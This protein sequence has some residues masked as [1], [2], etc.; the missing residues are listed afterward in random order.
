[1]SATVSLRRFPIK[2]KDVPSVVR[3][4][5]VVKVVFPVPPA[6]FLFVKPEA[7]RNPSAGGL[8]LLLLAFSLRSSALP[9]ISIEL[10]IS[11]MAEFGEV[12]QEAR[13]VFDLKG[14]K[15]LG[16]IDYP[17]RPIDVFLAKQRFQIVKPDPRKF[18]TPFL[19]I[20]P[21]SFDPDKKTGY[22]GL[23]EG[24]EVIFGRN[25]PY[26]FQYNPEV[27]REHLSI[28]VERGKI[29]FKDLNSTNGSRVEIPLKQAV[30]PKY[31]VPT[32]ETKS[33]VGLSG[34]VELAKQEIFEQAGKRSPGEIKRL[35]SQVEQILAQ[36]A[37]IGEGKL[38]KNIEEIKNGSNGQDYFVDGKIAYLPQKGD[39]I[40]IGDTHGDSQATEAIVKQVK[41]IENMERGHKERVLVFLGDYADRGSNDV[42]NLEIVLALKE[43]YPQNVILMMG[44]HEEGGGFTP[45][46]LPNSL[47][48]RFGPR[49]GNDLH[50]RYV[51]LFKHLPNVVVTA[52]GIVAVHGGVPK[53]NP[54]DLHQLKNNE[55]LFSQIR[56]NDP[57]PMIQE[58]TP[59]RRGDVFYQFGQRPFERFMQAVGG[60]VM[61]RS[62]EYP[63]AGYKLFF[64]NRLVTIF[65]NGGESRESGYSGRVQPK[66]MRA[67]LVD[68]ISQITPANLLPVQ[69]S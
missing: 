42:R 20:D 67:S 22:K 61:V 8:N 63:Q 33:E 10:I 68:S 9:Q 18:N 3:S 37:K 5:F 50:N 28:K 47:N 64:G 32:G 13:Q 26:R 17:D 19:L 59:S 66:I 39:A 49:D 24:V 56:W 51:S 25:H 60:K 44:N 7:K 15:N 36:E 48:Q 11:Y 6:V 57:D 27:S 14:G 35:I 69:Y 12:P 53:E 40:F 2:A 55:V 46:E 34:N 38:G 58:T 16:P 41:F 54:Q 30:A 52:N 29:I 45:Y 62:H 43:K 4:W 31:Q 1:M 65:S 21:R 23:W